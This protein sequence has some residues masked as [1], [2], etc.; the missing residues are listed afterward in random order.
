MPRLP[1]GTYVPVVTPF[2]AA[3]EIDY[4]ALSGVINRLLAA[5]VDALI[6]LGTTGESP[7]VTEPE[8]CRIIQHTLE[9]TRGK[10]PV[11]AGIGSY[12]T[13]SSVFQAK[14]A[15]GLGVQ[16]L[17]VVCP[18]YSKPTQD[19]IQAHYQAIADAISIPLL[20]YNITGRTGVNIETDTLLSMSAHPNIMG[21]KEASNDI[22]QIGEVL[23][24]LPDDFLV[25]SGCDHLNYPLM[26]LGGHGVISTLANIVPR[27]VKALVEAVLSNDY[28]TARKLHFQLL[29]LAHGCFIEANPIPIKTALAMMG[30]ITESFRLPITPMQASNRARWQAILADYGSLG[31]ENMVA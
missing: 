3:G 9:H 4:P 12:D 5:E 20:V 1:Y 6:M 2:T 30:E 23:Q 24:Q 10:I 26:C 25:L 18:Y 15:E 22:D 7:T 11:L 29:P 16:G 8:F 21:V 17:L 31:R 27:E 14:T 19:G 13:R 28:K